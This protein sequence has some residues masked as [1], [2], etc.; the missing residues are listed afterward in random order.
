MKAKAMSEAHVLYH[1][2]DLMV[3]SHKFTLHIHP[4][5]ETCSHCEPGCRA[6]T[7]AAAHTTGLVL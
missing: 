1:G 7:L 4:R 3:A 2:D 6:T 5:Q